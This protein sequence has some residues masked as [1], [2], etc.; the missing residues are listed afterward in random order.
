MKLVK[1]GISQGSF[2]SPIFASFYLASLLDI[3]ETPTNSIEI[4]ENYVYNC[5]NSKALVLT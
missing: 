4:S 2:I 3:L 5:Y 1:N